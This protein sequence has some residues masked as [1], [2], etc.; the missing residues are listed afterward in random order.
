MSMK[1]K[2]L[3]LALAGMVA[4]PVVANATV[5]TQPVGGLDTQEHTANVTIDGT[6]TKKDGTAA[7]G[8]IQVE[9]PTAMTFTVDKDGNF[10]APTNY[11]VTNNSSCPVDIFVSEFRESEAAGGITLHSYATLSQQRAS[12]DRSNI[13]LKLT[14][15]VGSE[16]ELLS[17]IN[18]DKQLFN[19]LAGNG[20]KKSVVL[21]GIAGTKTASDPV[22]GVQGN[23]SS[24]TVDDI[25]VSETFTVKFKVKK[26]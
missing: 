14:G 20:A 4:M 23:S 3:A 16:V 12:K 5:P 19:D 21:S 2:F 24:S 11:E 15:D 26:A 17:T 22:Q 18:S 10:Q 25:G 1:K 8:R 13:A 9:I 7:A 6:V